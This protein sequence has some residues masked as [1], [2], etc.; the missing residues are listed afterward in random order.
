MIFFDENDEEEQILEKR[1]KKSKLMAYFDFIDENTDVEF[2]Y[3]EM[4]KYC[5]W[6][7]KLGKWQLRKK[8][9]KKQSVRTDV[10]G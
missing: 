8:P 3:P 7:S 10:S 5:T 1:D 9:R 2:L 4:P 6:N